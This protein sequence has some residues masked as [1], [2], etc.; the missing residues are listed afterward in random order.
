MRTGLTAT[1]PMR[2]P[3]PAT[4]LAVVAAALL[5]CAIGCSVESSAGTAADTSAG[6]PAGAA[7]S[8]PP[9]IGGAVSGTIQGSRV[10]LREATFDGDL[11]VFEKEGWGWSP[12]VLIFLFLDDKRPP[13]GETIRVEAGGGFDVHRPHVHY[14]WQPP[15]DETLHV[16]VAMDEYDMVLR[17]GE[18]EGEWLPGTLELSIPSKG[19]HIRG[20]FRAKIKGQALQASR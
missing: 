7:A 4:L 19:T 6:A 1:I 8:S 14:R 15:D 3:L 5:A 2:P 17:F 9:P 16:D 12:S 13:E 18:V 20:S 10:A 11:A